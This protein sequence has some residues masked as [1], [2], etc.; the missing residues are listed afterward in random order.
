[1]T[2]DA[3]FGPLSS[4]RSGELARLYVCPMTVREGNT[5][6][7]D[8][9]VTYRGDSQPARERERF[10]WTTTRGYDMIVCS[11]VYVT[12]LESRIIIIIIIIIGY[13]RLYFFKRAL[14]LY[15]Y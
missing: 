1:M 3:I 12:G 5:W 9:G 4:S 2:T 11:F 10:V 14:I 15:V 13:N 6:L 8:D 7:S